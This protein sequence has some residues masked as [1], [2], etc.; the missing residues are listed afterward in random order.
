MLAHTMM[1]L[2]KMFRKER[3]EVYNIKKY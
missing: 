3:N 2:L 1:V